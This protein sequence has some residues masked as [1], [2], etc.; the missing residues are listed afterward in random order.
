MGI[1]AR[2]LQEPPPDCRALNPAVSEETSRLIK[3]M[4]AKSPEE[5]HNSWDE[6]IT[7]IET[8]LAETE[9]SN[10]MNI[11]KRTTREKARTHLVVALSLASLLALFILI[12]STRQPS[13]T[14]REID[15]FPEESASSSP[16]SATS[17]LTFPEP[18]PP[19]PKREIVPPPIKSNEK[20]AERRPEANF[21]DSASNINTAASPS[22]TSTAEVGS[23]VRARSASIFTTRNASRKNDDNAKLK[24][25]SSRLKEKLSLTDEQADALA[26]I[27]SKYIR[28]MRGK[29]M[30]LVDSGA[31]IRG[32]RD[33]SELKKTFE[34]AVEDASKILDKK[35]LSKFRKGLYF[36]TIR[37]MKRKR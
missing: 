20:N 18:S 34:K 33:N 2:H 24:Q 1:L 28:E 17:A 3:K 25:I 31:G 36:S 5:R 21:A 12:I 23:A 14:E 32:I 15:P 8:I 35:R 11:K 16:P 22:D 30:G 26:K 4:M 27:V 29:I 10:S 19:R 9:N 37:T 7:E 13:E 6:L